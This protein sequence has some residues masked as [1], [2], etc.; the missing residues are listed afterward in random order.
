[1]QRVICLSKNNK[2]FQAATDEPVA[3][4]E[5]NEDE[6]GDEPPKEWSYKYILSNYVNLIKLT[7]KT[8]DDVCYYKFDN[9]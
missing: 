5:E 3:G 7:L 2:K 1:M 6:E 9:V 4:E 8:G